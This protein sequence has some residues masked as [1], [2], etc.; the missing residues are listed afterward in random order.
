MKTMDADLFEDIIE[1]LGRAW[2]EETNPWSSTG[3]AAP[4]I[5]G[6][7]IFHPIE[8][9]H[10]AETITYPYSLHRVL[11]NR[12]WMTYC[13]TTMQTGYV[14]KTTDLHETVYEEKSSSGIQDIELKVSIER[15]IA[16]HTKLLSRRKEKVQERHSQPGIP[17]QDYKMSDLELEEQD[18][19]LDY[20]AMNARSRIEVPAK[21]NWKNV[22]ASKRSYSEIFNIKYELDVEEEL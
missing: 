15:D 2:D 9:L 20:S 16:V 7:T 10:R 13:L 11:P 4:S 21:V 12:K 1:A 14:G 5:P 17:T 3:T 8:Q 22:S 19:E 18:I 6:V